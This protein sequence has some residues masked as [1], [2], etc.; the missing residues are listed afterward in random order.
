MLC[1]IVLELKLILGVFEFIWKKK[2]CKLFVI[3]VILV[4]VVISVVS[5]MMILNRETFDYSFYLMTHR[6]M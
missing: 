3:V 6:T 2:F 1:V 4:V 5:N